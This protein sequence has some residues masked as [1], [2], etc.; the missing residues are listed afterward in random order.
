MDSKATTGLPFY[1]KSEAHSHWTPTSSILV[2]LIYNVNSCTLCVFF[3]LQPDFVSILV[4][5]GVVIVRRNVYKSS[6]E[7]SSAF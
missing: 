7:I 2:N 1:G 3:G 4:G 5:P 6:L